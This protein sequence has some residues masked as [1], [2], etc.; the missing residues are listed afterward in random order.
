MN[1]QGIILIADDNENNLR[2]LSTMLH[3]ADYSVRIA[4][5]GLQVLN[6][7]AL[8][9]P[10]L[11]LL[12]I[13]MPE[14]DGYQTC[15]KLKENPEYSEIPVIFISAL[16]ETFNKV[17]AFEIG[18][19]DYITKPFQIEEVKMRIRTH[20]LLRKRTTELEKALEEIKRVQARLIQSEKIA[21]LGVLSAGIAHEINN[22]IN[23][24]YAGINSLIKNFAE[25][26]TA[27]SEM[28]DTARNLPC[29]DHKTFHD[30]FASKNIEK[31]LSN[32]PQLAED[33]RVGAIRTTEIVKGL[34]L[35]ARTDHEE[36]VSAN[37]SE[38]I[39]TALLLLKNQYKN[40]IQIIKQYSDIPAITCYP[41]QLSQAFL[42]ILH[43]A[44]DA[45][46]DKGAITIT[47]G[48]NVSQIFVSFEDN[49]KGIPQEVMPKIFDPFFTTKAIG[50]GMGLGLAIT[51]GI[52]EKH[53]GNIAVESK[54]GKG[55]KFTITLPLS[56]K[57][58]T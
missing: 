25:L 2:V 18:G 43:N 11:I 42:N 21:S 12:D 33:I 41:G 54:P 30:V 34:K 44:I 3:Q 14:M 55:T 57:T 47:L 48:V 8:S 50:K 26:Q 13:H 38:Y 46:D 52:I 49:G 1:H 5:N 24:V 4:K 53:R 17:H 27:I 45:I 10:D 31:R 20:L 37:I 36:T 22:P 16:T 19:V 39:E 32:I 29:L 28:I 7:V 35:F 6:N 15:I 56:I 58:G 40:R 9:K 51:H 23:F